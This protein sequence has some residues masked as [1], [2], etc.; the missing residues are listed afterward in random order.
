MT[1]AT[2]PSGF[3]MLMLHVKHFRQL[4]IETLEGKLDK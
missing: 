1:V 4:S 3:G 2:T